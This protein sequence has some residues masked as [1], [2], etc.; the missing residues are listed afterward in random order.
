MITVETW[1]QTNVM[2]PVPLLLFFAPFDTETSFFSHRLSLLDVQSVI[3]KLFQLLSNRVLEKNLCFPEHLLILQIFWHFFSDIYLNNKLTGSRSGS[4]DS[5]TRLFVE[6]E[7]W[8]QTYCGKSKDYHGCSFCWGLNRLR[9]NWG[10][11]L[12][13]C[14]CVDAFKKKNKHKAPQADFSLN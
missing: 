2:F 4:S 9:N 5:P 13:V 6:S 1:T 3:S 10:I 7:L 14:V 11:N 12:C 8:H